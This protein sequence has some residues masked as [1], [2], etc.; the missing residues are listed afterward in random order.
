MHHVK[1]NEGYERIIQY[2]YKLMILINFIK[3]INISIKHK[4][5]NILNKKPDYISHR[6]VKLNNILSLNKK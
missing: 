6:R 5:K 1:A 2:V 4:I 3:F